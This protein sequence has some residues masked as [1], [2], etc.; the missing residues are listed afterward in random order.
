M[1][2]LKQAILNLISTHPLNDAISV[3]WA[4]EKKQAK[5]PF[6]RIEPIVSTSSYWMN[7]SKDQSFRVQFS[8]FCKDEDKCYEVLELIKDCFDD[9]KLEYDNYYSI[10][11]RSY[12]ENGINYIDEVYQYIIEYE[13][14]R[15]K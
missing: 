9:A 15:A 2:E 11:C 5:S 6:L 10:G 12:N 4:K 3:F 8:I 13:I 1:R 14:I 7:K